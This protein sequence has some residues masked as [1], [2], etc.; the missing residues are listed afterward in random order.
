[1]LTDLSI[2]NLLLLKACDIPFAGGLNVL[3]GETGAGKSILLDALGLVLGERSD[4]GLVRAGEASASV[5]AEFDIGANA[6]ARALL[7]EL[8]LDAAEH[9][10]LRRTLAADGKS[11]AFINDAPVS[12]AALKRFGEV[13]VARHGQHDQRGLL[14]SKSHRALLDAYGKHASLVTETA[15]KFAAWKEAVAAL[16]QLQEAAERAARDEAWLRQIAEELGAL[17]PQANEEEQLTEKRKRAQEAKQSLG[18]LREALSLLTESDG[19]ALQLRQVAKLLGRTTLVEASVGETLEAAENA[20]EEVSVAIERALSAADIDPAE[21]EA[22][23]DRLHALRGASRKFGVAVALLPDLLADARVK[24][25]TLTNLTRETKQANDALAAAETEYKRAAETL[26][27]AREKAGEKMVR[28][29][30]K[31]LKALKMASTQLRVVQ[32]ALPPQSW[33]EGG[34]HQVSFEVATNAGMPFGSLNKVASG[35]EL[36]RLLLAMKVVL[37]AGGPTTSIFDEIDTGTGGAVAEAIGLRLKLLAGS[38]QMIVVTHAPQ[39][40]ALAKHHLFISKAGTKAITTQVEVLDDAARKE[41]L[42]RMLSGATISDEARKAA[43]KL[44]EAAL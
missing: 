44:L 12:A 38:T 2:R 11:R 27:A 43:G 29:V 17:D 16:A 25:A 24:V 30:V 7:E 31:E 41:E 15:S 39:V 18:A 26:F 14:D 33:G 6:A 13:L 37:H 1:M 19:A 10:V 21:I 35:G 9:L 28:E 40:A 34:M 5:A 22:A 23:E 42:A 20:V 36:S 4:A 8:E 3:T 32:S